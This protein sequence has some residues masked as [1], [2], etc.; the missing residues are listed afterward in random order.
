[1]KEIPTSVKLRAL[2]PEDLDFLYSLENDPEYWDVGNTNVP[3]SHFSLTNYI[4]GSTSDIYGD[5]Q[6]RLVIEN[7]GKEAVG[8]LDL[9]NFDPKHRRAEVGI[10]VVRK[11]RGRGLGHAALLKA[12]DYARQ[13]LHLRQLYAF[14]NADNSKSV[15]LFC[16]AGFQ[17][18][19][20]LK[21]WFYDGDGYQDAIVMQ[22]LL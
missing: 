1:M 2:E 10:A 20:R 5:K 22:L 15:Q 3:Y 7:E 14:A 16:G 4:M 6:M 9:F 21:Q 19:A 8:L 18:G 12:V 13:V 17:Q 11:E